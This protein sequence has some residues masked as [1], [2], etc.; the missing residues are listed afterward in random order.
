MLSAKGSKNNAKEGTKEICASAKNWLHVLDTEY[1]DEVNHAKE[2]TVIVLSNTNVPYCVFDY[3]YDTKVSV[4]NNDVIICAKAAVSNNKGSR[5]CVLNFASPSHPGGGFLKGAIAQEECICRASGLYPCLS[6]NICKGWYLTKKGSAELPNSFI[7]VKDCPF[8][9]NGKSY[10]VDVLTMAAPNIRDKYINYDGVLK[11]C[12]RTAYKVPAVFGADIVLLGAWGCGV[13][14]N[15]PVT[16]ACNWK[17]MSAEYPGV[18][19]EVVHPVLDKRMYKT[20][21]EVL[22]GTGGKR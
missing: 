14:G 16:V 2:N 5:V 11:E 15:D 6:Q 9:V 12:Q 1:S 4:Y 7:Y 21:R 22:L 20:F 18:Y 17:E 10:I 3:K 19:H 8:I 13:F